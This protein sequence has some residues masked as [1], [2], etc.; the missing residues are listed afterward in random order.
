MSIRQAASRTSRKAIVAAARDLR[1]RQTL[2]EQLLWDALRDRR[3]L[4]QKFR[5]QARIGHHV[6]DFYCPAERLVIEVDGGIHERMRSDD[7]HRQRVLEAADLRVLR[8]SANACEHD[9]DGVLQRIRETFRSQTDALP[10]PSTR[11]RGRG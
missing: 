1:Q 5:R 6:V 7:R 3:Q 9:I 4:G 8:V 2:S 11:E 10:S